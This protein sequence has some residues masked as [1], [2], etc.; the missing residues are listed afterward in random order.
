[1]KKRGL[2]KNFGELGLNELLSNAK[3]DAADRL[4]KLP[5]DL[6]QPGKYQPRRDMDQEAL[7][8]LANSIKTQ[9]IIQ[10][11]IVRPIDQ[12]RYE[13]I[14]GERRWRAAQ[15][16]NLHEVPAVIRDIPDEAAIA[17]SLIENIQRED[18]NAIE[19]AAALQRLINEFGMTHQ[20]IAETVGKSRTTITNLLRLLNLE[21]NVKT[22][23]ELGDIE[24]GHARALLALTNDLQLSAAKTIVA[25]NLSVREAERLVNNLQHK[26]TMPIA[27]KIDPDINKVQM[28]LAEK[29]KA[30]VIIQHSVKGSGKLIIQYNSLDELEGIIEHI[31]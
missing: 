7:Q 27:K 16:A 10:P 23:L 15:L 3:S 14:A 28:S 5:I 6:M 30:R 21:K 19:E 20:Q 2:G 4:R 18:L 17:M 13:I 11:I 31:K 9:G 22:M 8:E 12:N 24:M 29:L 26:K 1:M 25:K